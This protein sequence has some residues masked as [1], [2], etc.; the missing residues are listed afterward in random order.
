MGSSADATAGSLGSSSGATACC[1]PGGLV[2]AG[3]GT[4]GVAILSGAVAASGAELA[5]TTGADLGSGSS[6]G[7]GQRAPAGQAVVPGG[8]ERPPPPQTIPISSS[9]KQKHVDYCAAEGGNVK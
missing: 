3:N 6:K 7:A 8:D 4:S 5:A 9:I 1:R 2:R